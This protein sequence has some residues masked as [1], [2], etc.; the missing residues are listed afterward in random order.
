MSH[1]R[2]R[3]VSTLLLAFLL[4]MV[5]THAYAQGGSTTSTLSGTVVDSSGGVIPGAD[6]V[7]KNNATATTYTSVSGANGAFSIPAVDPGTYTV[8]V[9]IAPPSSAKDILTF[10]PGA[11]IVGTNIN[12]SPGRSMPLF[13]PKPKLVTRR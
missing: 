7:A 2:S 12:Y 4:A 11:V 5:G 3:L 9:T 13:E 1:G 6:V 10:G 8:T